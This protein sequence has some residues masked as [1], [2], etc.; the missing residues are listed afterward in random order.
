MEGGVEHTG[1][2]VQART[3]YVPSEIAWGFAFPNITEPKGIVRA[4][5]RSDEGK[6]MSVL[7]IRDNLLFLT[8]HLG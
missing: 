4:K 7:R 6:R 3:S 1:V 8:S 5:Q 2:S